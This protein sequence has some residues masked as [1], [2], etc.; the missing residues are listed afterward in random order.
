MG[1]ESTQIEAR[2]NEFRPNESSLEFNKSI[3]KNTESSVETKELE[4]KESSN[5]ERPIA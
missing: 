1:K 2:S 3:P 4:I 5:T